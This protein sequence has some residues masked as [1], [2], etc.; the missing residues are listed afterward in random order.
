M[1][2]LTALHLLNLFVHNKPANGVKH[3]LADLHYERVKIIKITPIQQTEDVSIPPNSYFQLFGFVSVRIYYLKK[4][5]KMFKD[6]YLYSY[7]R[8]KVFL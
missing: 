1:S 8:G 5:N 2:V 7:I 4:L 3:I 6:I